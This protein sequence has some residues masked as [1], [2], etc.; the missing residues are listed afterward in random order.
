MRDRDNFQWRPNDNSVKNNLRYDLEAMKWKNALKS[1]SVN[2]TASFSQTLGVVGM[3]ISLLLNTV[4]FC[5]ICLVD[6]SVF[7]RKLFK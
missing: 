1:A 5:L 3:I 6:V 7:I 2:S 4:L